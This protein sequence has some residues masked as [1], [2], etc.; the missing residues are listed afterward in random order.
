MY[1]WT[2]SFLFVNMSFV[3]ATATGSYTREYFVFQYTCTLYINDLDECVTCKILKFADDIKLR[4][5]D[6]NTNC[7]MTLI[8]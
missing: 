6:M 8:N 3:G 4:K 1:L 2:E 7:K 5:L